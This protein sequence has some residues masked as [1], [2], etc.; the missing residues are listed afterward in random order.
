[1]PQKTLLLIGISSL[2]MSNHRSCSFA[3]CILEIFFPICLKAILGLRRLLLPEVL[4][5]LLLARAAACYLSKMASTNGFRSVCFY[6]SLL[7]FNLTLLIGFTC[8]GEH[9]LFKRSLGPSSVKSSFQQ[10]SFTV[11]VCQLWRVTFAQ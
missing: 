9:F 1:M 8:L 4:L 2:F 11:L 10:S 6:N 7:I 3:Y 5:L